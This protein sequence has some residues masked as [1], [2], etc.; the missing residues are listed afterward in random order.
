MPDTPVRIGHAVSNTYAPSD[1][2][3][4]APTGSP[5]DMPT[6]KRTANKV[7]QRQKWNAVCQVTAGI[8]IGA[9]LSLIT[10][11]RVVGG[12]GNPWT[13]PWFVLCLFLSLLCAVL[14]HIFAGV[15][16]G[17]A[18]GYRILYLRVLMWEW[19]CPPNTGEMHRRVSLHGAWGGLCI[20]YEPPV[21]G[22]RDPL[23]RAM[24]YASGSGG[25]ILTALI[26]SAVL[27]IVDPHNEYVLIAMQCFIWVSVLYAV[28]CM[29]PYYSGYFP[30][31]GMLFW[32]LILR[33]A[34]Q[35]QLL[36]LRYVRGQIYAGTRPRNILVFRPDA[37]EQTP[38]DI[39]I[40]GDFLDD[41][42]DGTAQRV[43][44]TNELLLLWYRYLR[45]TDAGNQDEANVL[46]Y[47]M[48][49]MLPW[50]PADMRTHIY[51][52][53]C[54]RACLDNNPSQAK[55]YF[56]K[57][58]PALRTDRSIT[59][60]RVRAYY[61][62]Y[63]L[64]NAVEAYRLCQRGLA[65][66]REQPLLRGLCET[67]RD[68]LTSLEAQCLETATMQSAMS[69]IRRMRRRAAAPQKADGEDTAQ[70][71]VPESDHSETKPEHKKE[72]TE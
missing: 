61:T 20:L 57:S 69:F 51:Y 63:A 4:T 41:P 27:W 68:I 10:L 52:E 55:Y 65:S 39:L 47:L 48:R 59:A 5:S 33:R 34:D 6:G 72:G 66:R 2:A 37:G 22:G 30:T 54:F 12:L 28:V 45:E 67:E 40:D 53:L 38:E 70:Q 9:A 7:E 19:F 42:D 24:Q 3:T 16:A 1:R 14:F 13:L 11:A 64:G 46:L 21:P 8:L 36:W 58:E 35:E 71:T 44:G 26:V 29:I 17:N 32:N 43:P 56:D 60:Y 50:Y 23:L 25:N 49:R 15:L 31:D 62:Y 18:V